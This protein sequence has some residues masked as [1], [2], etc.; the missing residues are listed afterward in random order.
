MGAR[1][2][3]LVDEELS[4]EQKAHLAEVLDDTLRAK[5]R[6]AEGAAF[7]LTAAQKAEGD[8]ALIGLAGVFAAYGHMLAEI[9]DS[10]EACVLDGRERAS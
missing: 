9:R 4:A 5:L 7:L 10:L 2:V 1:V 6:I 8:S 3:S